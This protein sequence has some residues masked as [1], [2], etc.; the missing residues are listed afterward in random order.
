MTQLAER[1]HGGTLIALVAALGAGAL[2]A[3][4]HTGEVVHPQPPPRVEVGLRDSG[5]PAFVK[6]R[7]DATYELTCVAGEFPAAGYFVRAKYRTTEAWERIGVVSADGKKDL[8]AFADRPCRFGDARVDYEGVDLDHDGTMELIA[9]A[10]P[11]VES[12][13]VAI[14]VLAVHADGVVTVPGPALRATSLEIARS[15]GSLDLVAPGTS[16]VVR[17]RVRDGVLV[18][19]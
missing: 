15:S 4:R 3:P 9:T 5:C 17:Y 1:I 14:E 18:T 16:E 2:L 11:D 13:V 8:A 19:P 6:A 7:F 10:S 12:I